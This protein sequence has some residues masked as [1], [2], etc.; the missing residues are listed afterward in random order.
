MI[1]AGVLAIGAL[2]LEWLQYNYYIKMYTTPIYIGLLVVGFMGLG[3]WLG[4]RL[5]NS[6]HKAPFEQNHKALYTLK[7]TNRE[8]AVLTLLAKG[9][10]NKEIAR[11]LGISPNTVKTHMA[12]LFRKLQV[13]SRL[14]AVNLAQS[15]HLVARE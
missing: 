7:I 11:S 3:V 1:Y 10:S 8:Q 12:R 15:L 2:L 9:K 5:G 4:L 13:Q 14:Q 6:P